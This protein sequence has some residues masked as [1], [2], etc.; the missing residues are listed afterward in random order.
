MDSCWDEECE[1]AGEEAGEGEAEGEG[2]K[3]A[4]AEADVEVSWLE[5]W[6]AVAAHNKGEEAVAAGPGAGCI[7]FALSHSAQCLTSK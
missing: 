6:T 7:A 5:V 4:E 1:G 2:P 3:V